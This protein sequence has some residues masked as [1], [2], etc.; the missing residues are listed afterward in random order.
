MRASGLTE[1][2]RDF[3]Y[4]VILDLTH[5]QTGYD[6]P[7]VWSELRARSGFATEA[8]QRSYYDRT[9]GKTVEVRSIFTAA[10]GVTINGQYRSAEHGR[11]FWI[12]V[13]ADGKLSQ[14]A[15]C[16]ADAAPF[17]DPGS[18]SEEQVRQLCPK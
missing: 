4:V 1:H 12:D 16:A 10:G 2:G 9:S 14:A 3:A 15:Q 8:M 18:L 7:K 11:V 5:F 13:A 6:Y 17:R